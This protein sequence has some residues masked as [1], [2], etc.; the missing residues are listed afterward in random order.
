MRVAGLDVGRFKDATAYVELVEHRDLGTSICNQCVRMVGV[1]LDEQRKQLEPLVA[2]ADVTCID[3]NGIGLGLYEALHAAMPNNRV[4]G[5]RIVRGATPLVRSGFYWSVGKVW[6]IARLSRAIRRG[7]VTFPPWL[8][9]RER[10]KS[11]L[12]SL[13]GTFTGRGS[14]RVEAATG[15]DDL[16]I[17][18][19]LAL[20]AKDLARRISSHGSPP[21]GTARRQACG[22]GR[23]TA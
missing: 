7:E 19:A 2:Q 4:T 17:G 23:D 6:L 13:A 3:M 14:V 15:H 1:S 22:E 8:D 5:V 18:L 12:L 10:L 11:E 9:N 21:Q 16:A 20:L